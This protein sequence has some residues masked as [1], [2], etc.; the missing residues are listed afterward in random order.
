[1]RRRRKERKK[2]RR[3]HAPARRISPALVAH[4]RGRLTNPDGGKDGAAYSMSVAVATTV[5]LATNSSL[6]Q[7]SN[8]DGHIARRTAP[9]RALARA[10]TVRGVAAAVRTTPAG[11]HSESARN[12]APR[13]VAFAHAPQCAL[14]VALLPNLCCAV[15]HRDRC[16]RNLRCSGRVAAA[17]LHR[18][19]RRCANP[20]ELVEICARQQSC[21]A[22]VHHPLCRFSSLSPRRHST[23]LAAS[24]I[25][26]I[27]DEE[28]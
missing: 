27:L 18:L 21:E 10:D 20:R 15:L 12:T 11:T 23:T 19:C 17:F 8:A 13:L 16:E 6:S 22:M 25:H 7:R 14:I 3:T 26:S 1:M 5:T 28:Y 4:A 2:E 9:A 24:Y